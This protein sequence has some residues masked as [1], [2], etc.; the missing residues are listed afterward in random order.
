MHAFGRNAFASRKRKLSCKM[1]F[2]ATVYPSFS[3]SQVIKRV[4]DRCTS[5]QAKSEQR[6][7]KK[8]GEREREREGRPKKRRVEGGKEEKQKAKKEKDGAEKKKVKPRYGCT[9]RSL[10]KVSIVFRSRN[11]IISIQSS[12]VT[13]QWRRPDTCYTQTT[14]KRKKRKKGKKEAT[15]RKKDKGGEKE[16]TSIWTSLKALSQ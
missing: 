1:R 4:E 14:I 3:L 7:N 8:K 2:R 11:A 10:I 6:D 5:K 13:L 9:N 12:L 15:R 16:E